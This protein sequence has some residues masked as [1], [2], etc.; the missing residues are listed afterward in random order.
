MR[1]ISAN[2][3]TTVASGLGPLSPLMPT[4]EITPGAR[5]HAHTVVDV[6]GFRTA[7][8]ST[9]MTRSTSF[10]IVAGVN[11]P[12]SL[13]EIRPDHVTTPRAQGVLPSALSP[14][15][16]RVLDPNLLAVHSLV[17]DRA[18]RAVV[19]AVNNV[20]IMDGALNV[21]QRSTGVGTAH[22]WASPS[23]VT[24]TALHT[25]DV[26]DISRTTPDRIGIGLAHVLH[27]GQGST[28]T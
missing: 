24:T 5:D 4:L 10:R 1:G 11:F 22:L 25:V 23:H 20:A 3:L 26:M 13:T 28:V 14:P 19:E 16:L 15:N 12:S 21:A 9:S 18:L 27:H 6:I 17:A 8:I 2:L 7:V